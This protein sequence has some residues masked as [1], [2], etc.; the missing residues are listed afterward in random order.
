MNNIS[1]LKN[2]L[3]GGLI[4][5][6]L[7]SSCNFLDVV[8]PEQATLSDATKTYEA[9]LGFLYSCYTGVNTGRFN[10]NDVECASDEYVCPPLWAAEQ[11]GVFGLWTPQNTGAW[12][13]GNNYYR[14]IGQCHLFAQ[15]LEKVP[16]SVVSQE[17]KAQML[18]EKEFLLGYY[19]MQLLQEYGPI[20]IND[21]YIDM[22]ADTGDYPGRS[23]YDYVVDYIVSKF[24]AAAA[25]LPATRSGEE[26][27]RATS[28][29]AKGYKS[30]LL[31][32]A[33]SPLWNGE[34]PYPEWRNKKYETPGYGLELVSKNYDPQKWV[35]AKE[36][37][38]EALDLALANGYY[39]FEDKDLND[40]EN[41][42]LPYVPGID[43]T[44]PEGKEFQERVMIMRYAVTTR[45][46]N[47]K[48]I[49]WGTTN[50]G[51]IIIG[52]LPHFI[53][54]HTNG[55]RIGGYSGVSPLLNTSIAYFYTEN[56]KRPEDDPEF[57]S[58]DQWFKTA[59]IGGSGRNRII[60]LNVHREPRF[61]AWF[62]FDGGD[63]G[64]SIKNGEPL[65]I[66][67]LS[68]DA[69]GTNYS[70]F[71][72]DNNVTGYFNQKFLPPKY[73]YNTSGKIV[74]GE[75]K[76]RPMMRLAEL[77]LNLA[78][79]QAALGENDKAIKSLNVIRERAGVPGLTTSDITPNMSMTDWVRN[80]RLDRKSVV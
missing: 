60:N 9:T 13:W 20:P 2:A 22:N 54:F 53:Q 63:Y 69:Q 47:N 48:E 12:R 80:E 59:N 76:P 67:M 17:K 25:V 52:S 75:S 36:A 78:E 70:L 7:L 26:W 79:A 19:H 41:V 16:D 43:P 65:Q 4:S 34:F 1:L 10:Y 15:E 23:H 51:N 37:T 72:R 42:E 3:A 45:Y 62:G 39:L 71:P 30:R 33:A 11:Q 77:Y 57:V 5:M 14:F 8:P 68:K 21:E 6:T 55:S 32:Y 61:Y 58:K 49:I 74:N 35:R 73:A 38:Q 46:A 50:Q 66:N 56:G 18:A 44:T 28:V 24:D 31:V 29:M 27:G 40:R 64:N